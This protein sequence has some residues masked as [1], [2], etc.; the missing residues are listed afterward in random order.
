MEEKQF[1]KDARDKMRAMPTQ[2][3]YMLLMQEKGKNKDEEQEKVQYW[4]DKLR[5]P[6][7]G[8]AAAAAAA[9]IAAAANPATGAAANA[10]LPAAGAPLTVENLQSLRVVLGG[11]GKAWLK[12]FVEKEGLLVLLGRLTKE[13]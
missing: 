10:A 7:A 6:A 12:E 5:G 4:V 1:K 9:A 2:Y 11:Q 3:K 8:A 13:G